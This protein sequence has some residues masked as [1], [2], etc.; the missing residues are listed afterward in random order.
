MILNHKFYGILDQGRGVLEVY[1]G[2]QDD[3]AYSKAYEVISN[4]EAVVDNLFDRVKGLVVIAP[5]KPL[6]VTT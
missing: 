6:T 2:S 3:V 5:T 4:M 1:E